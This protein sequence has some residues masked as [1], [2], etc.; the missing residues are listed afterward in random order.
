MVGNPLEILHFFS[1]HGPPGRSGWAPA[2]AGHAAAGRRGSGAPVADWLRS[3]G[4]LLQRGGTRRLWW[5]Y[6]FLV[7]EPGFTVI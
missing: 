1:A 2:G 3:L 7:I 4:P 5:D 6:E